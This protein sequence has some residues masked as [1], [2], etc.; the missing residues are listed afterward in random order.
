MADV[1]I[2]SPLAGTTVPFS[3]SAKGTYS[4]F[5]AADPKPGV[6]LD[7][8]NGGVIAT[9]THMMPMPPGSVPGD[10]AATFTVPASS[11]GGGYTELTLVA[12]L[13]AAG[14]VA[15][16]PNITVGGS[17]PPVIN[18]V[19][20]VPVPPPPGPV[21][22]AAA[23]AAEVIR[24]QGDFTAGAAVLVT[25]FSYTKNNR[26]DAILASGAATLNAPAAGQWTIDLTITLPLNRRLVVRALAFNAK[27]RVIGNGAIRRRK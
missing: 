20:F 27:G 9:G 10:W 16:E 26:L 19:V 6:R 21:V 13:V 4:P 1:D 3:F 12:E 25:A 8:I 17:S 24:V 14:E 18:N 7:D 22:A 5:T 11:T 2:L 23:A 15:E